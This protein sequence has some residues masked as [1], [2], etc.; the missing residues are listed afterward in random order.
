M[1]VESSSDTWSIGSNATKRGSSDI[2]TNAVIIPD[3]S[4]VFYKPG[5]VTGWRLYSTVAGI[6]IYLQ[7]WR[8][9]SVSRFEEILYLA[10]Q[11]RII[12]TVGF[13][14]VTLNATNQIAVQQ[15]DFLGIYFPTINPIPWDEVKCTTSDDLLRYVVDPGDILQI[16]DQLSFDVAPYA[17][18]PCRQYSASALG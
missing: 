7:I 12:S 2:V 9:N 8:L 15:G 10:G 18:S 13:M 1:V 14:T 4:G 6:T 17:F 11:T 5:N 3:F 16:G